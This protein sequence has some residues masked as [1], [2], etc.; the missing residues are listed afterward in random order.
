[1]IR[2]GVTKHLRRRGAIQAK[3]LGGGAQFKPWYLAVIRNS[4]AKNLW[5][6]GAVQAVVHGDGVQFP[7]RY[8]ATGCSSPR[9]TRVIRHGVA[10]EPLQAG[11]Y[12]CRCNRLKPWYTAEV[13]GLRVI[14][15]GGVFSFLFSRVNTSVSLL[16][17]K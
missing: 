5:R 3:V 13:L 4:V 16:L 14:F 9:G 6:R 12:S 15:S 2:Y 1:V 7:P 10:L 8:T 17:I 11:R